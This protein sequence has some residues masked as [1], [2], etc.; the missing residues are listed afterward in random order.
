M[1]HRVTSLAITLIYGIF[2]INFM[3][4]LYKQQRSL[5]WYSRFWFQRFP[6]EA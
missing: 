5:R 1:L 2:T 3:M 6:L 4:I